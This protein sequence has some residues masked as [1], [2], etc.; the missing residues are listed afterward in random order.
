MPL[1]TKSKPERSSSSL[2]TAFA[3]G[4]LLILSLLTSYSARTGYASLLE[5]RALSNGDLGAASAAVS[6]SP[7][8]PRDHQVL[9]ALLE[10]HDDLAAAIPHYQT[11]VRL[12]PEDYVLWMQLARGQEL[13]GN[14]EA[15]VD[16]GRAAVSFAP[17]YAQP[18]WQLGNIMVRAGRSEE[19]F[20]EL[21]LAGVSDP[22]LLPSIIDLA[23]QI[24]HGDVDFVKRATAPQTSQAY[25]AL[26]EYLKKRKNVTEAVAMFSA[27]GHESEATLARKQYVRELINAGNFKEAHQLWTVDREANADKS[28]GMLI[29]PG[30][31]EE[32]DLNESF[33]WSAIYTAKATTLS[34]D[35]SN[36]NE[37]ETSLRVD[38]NGENNPA[39]PIISQLVL[40]QPRTHYQFHV[41]FR[42]DGLVSG[43]LPNVLVVDA[44][45]NKM[46]TETGALPQTTAGWR[47]TTTDFTTGDATSAIRI[48]LQRQPCPTPQC[49]I[50]GKLWL[51][52]FS[53]K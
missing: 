26:G 20:S 8:N 53:L 11:A 1:E 4:L 29:D 49:P 21:R 9:G 51:D 28:T 13:E 40:V 3:F 44:A 42:T 33:G 43:G 37:G 2:R 19:G 47:D 50:F 38:F 30:F 24:S 25:L 41:A 52:N 23:W 39:A 32:S 12:R 27:A 22:A 7:G 15:A 18:H 31:E 17:F 36:P 6:L 14:S 16:S 34:L 10:A 5:V 45:D 48:A 35:N 46:L